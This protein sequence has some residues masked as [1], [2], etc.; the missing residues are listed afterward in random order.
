MWQREKSHLSGLEE[1][2]NEIS[3]MVC[4]GVGRGGVRGKVFMSLG[5]L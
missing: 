3:G 4:P 1:T 5:L 2:P